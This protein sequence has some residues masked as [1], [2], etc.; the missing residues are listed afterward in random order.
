MSEKGES[1]KHIHTSA[2]ET[3]WPDDP[4]CSSNDAKVTL[5]KGARKCGKWLQEPRPKYPQHLVIQ[6]APTVLSFL[7]F[8]VSE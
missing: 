4:R 7:L 2:S 5:D 1:H 8:A 3:E 6:K